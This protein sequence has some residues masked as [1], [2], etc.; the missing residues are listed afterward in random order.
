M[1]LGEGGG[2]GG[3]LAYCVCVPT[4]LGLTLLSVINYLV[5]VL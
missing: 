2:V 3:K 1:S 4:L 5:Q